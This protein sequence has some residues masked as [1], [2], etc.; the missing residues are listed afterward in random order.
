MSVHLFVESPVRAE[1][2]ASSVAEGAV[3]AGGGRGDAAIDL[4][5]ETSISM[6]F[7]GRKSREREKKPICGDI[8][9]I[10]KVNLAKLCTENTFPG[11]MSQ[12]DQ[13]SS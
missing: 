6:A 13:S 4:E 7:L 2:S 12:Q 8:L 9:Q 1:A 5:V 10:S 11:V 3:L